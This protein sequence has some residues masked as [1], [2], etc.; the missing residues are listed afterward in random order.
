RMHWIEEA[1]ETQVRIQNAPGDANG[2]PAGLYSYGFGVAEERFLQ[3]IVGGWE[4]VAELCDT[5][6]LP[7]DEAALLLRYL[8]V[9][10]RLDK[11]AAPSVPAGI[12]ALIQQPKELS[13]LT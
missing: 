1:R 12:S 5:G 2:L 11:R 8:E 4:K 9:I 10:G 6:T 7:P 13:Q 3:R